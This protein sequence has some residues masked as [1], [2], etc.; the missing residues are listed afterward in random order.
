M[1]LLEGHDVYVDRTALRALIKKAHQ[2]GPLFL[3]KKLLLL[4]FSTEELAHSC[5]QGLVLK[6]AGNVNQTSKS[7]LD[8]EK[9][10][11]QSERQSRNQ[12]L[13]CELP[14]KITN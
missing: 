1:R 14:L 4:V 12:I 5:G 9:E 6:Q 8:P 2:K 3:L 11:I 13:V 7:P 10:N